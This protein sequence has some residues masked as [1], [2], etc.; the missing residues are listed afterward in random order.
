M[1]LWDM[2]T[3]GGKEEDSGML[4]AFMSLMDKVARK[5]KI[6]D[7]LMMMLQ[8]LPMGSVAGQGEMALLKPWMQKAPGK[9][10][11]R[12]P[13]T[14]GAGGVGKQAETLFDEA[15]GKTPPMA[16]APS[17]APNLTQAMKQS[18][19]MLEWFKSMPQSAKPDL[20]KFLMKMYQIGM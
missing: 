14:P 9:M 12:I 18:P 17:G 20:I 5:T 6:P 8:T 4:Q 7:E 11:A 3:K 2:P 13:A 16:N 10:W 1:P 19:S 15:F